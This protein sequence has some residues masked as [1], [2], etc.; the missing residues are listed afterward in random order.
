MG[1]HKSL[2][3]L[4]LFILLI[5]AGSLLSYLS[6]SSAL[7][8]KEVRKDGLSGANT[9]SP[10]Y[11]NSPAYC[12]VEKEISEDAY[13]RYLENKQFRSWLKDSITK[14]FLTG[15]V[16]RSVHPM[17]AKVSEEHT[18]RNI[19]LLK[20]VY[21]A[22]IIM[23]K[24]AL[25]DGVKLIVTSGHRTFTEQVCEWELRWNNPRTEYSFSGDTEKARFVLQYRSMPGT[26]RHHWGTDIDLNSFHQS[27]FETVQGKKVYEW[28]R[29]NAPLY[30]FFQPYTPQDENRPTGYCEEKWHWS[31][32]PI[33]RPMLEHYIRKTGKEDIA[34][35]KGDG[36]VEH[37]NIMEEW[38][39]GIDPKMIRIG[40][41]PN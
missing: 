27:Y 22:Y 14:D 39:C 32:R 11:C 19:Y 23:Y 18:E 24:A 2:I 30:G 10:E 28:L 31:Y 12:N 26:S 34:G 38:V 37:L 33:A 7:P 25:A 8:G 3:S 9:I 21:E 29:A 1:K 40:R 35:F 36:A 15:K 41:T 13:K 4:F 6:Y 16:N 5:T 20:P 17:F